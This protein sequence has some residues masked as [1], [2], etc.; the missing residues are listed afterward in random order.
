MR[1]KLVAGNWKMFTS[2][3]S[4]RELARGVVQGVGTEQ[5]V[6]VVVCPPFPFL[7]LVAECV[8]GSAVALGAQNSYSQKE[9]AFTGEVSPVML[10]EIGCEYVIIGHSERRHQMGETDLEV[11]SKTKL[12]LDVGLRVI[13]CVGETLH[14][15]MSEQTE[16]VVLRQLTAGVSSIPVNL[17]RNL[18][19]AYE[20][21]WAIG[22]GHNATPNQA[23]AVHS[24][25]R[26][27]I[28]SLWGPAPA[29]R[30][31][32]LY[33]GSVKPDNAAE[34]LKQPDVDGGLIGGASLKAADFLAIFQAALAIA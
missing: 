28:A 24:F 33:G 8:Q 16:S 19:L 26:A 13:L 17:L 32:I 21:V 18:I 29:E 34:L 5:R 11:N 22:T 31:T 12:A 7:P 20:P 1:K 3:A 25:L 30:V 15:R 14:E 4:A 2:P 27:K 23:Q 6:G 10:K 9:G